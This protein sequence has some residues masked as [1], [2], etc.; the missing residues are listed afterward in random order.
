MIAVPAAALCITV[1]GRVALARKRALL[2][3]G[4]IQACLCARG[5]FDEGSAKTVILG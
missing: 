4:R 3:A 1:L 5:T 2:F